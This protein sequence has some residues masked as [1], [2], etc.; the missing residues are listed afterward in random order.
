MRDYVCVIGGANVDIEGRSDGVLR[1]HDSNIGSVR[2][3]AGGVGRNI[4]ENLARLGC[5]T[6][7]LTAL[8]RD[9]HGSWLHAQ[10]VAAGVDLADVLWCEDRPTPIYLSVL[11]ERGDM[12]TAINDMSALE[13]LGRDALAARDDAIASA[14]LIVVDCNLADDALE[15]LFTTHPEGLFFADTVSAAKAPRI[16]PYLSRLHTLKPNRIE[17][18]LLSGV[19]ITD[20]ASLNQACDRLLSQGPRQIFISLGSEGLFYA[21]ADDRGKLASLTTRVVST[22]GAGDALMAGIVYGHL[23]GGATES[24][25]QLARAASALTAQSEGAVSEALCPDRVHE[26]LKEHRG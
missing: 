15:F 9:T 14:L 5:P 10:T 12:L 16:R 23:Q 22:T 24:Q 26:I 21:S 17:A 25:A 18:S 8:G 20:N 3:A 4:A 2:V 11:D 7:L 13:R 1:M 6:R 19:E